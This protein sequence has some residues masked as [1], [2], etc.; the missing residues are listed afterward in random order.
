MSHFARL[1]PT[2]LLQ[3]TQKAI[4]SGELLQLHQEL[5]RLKKE[6]NTE[7]QVM[8]APTRL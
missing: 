2:E 3:E 8:A 4:G 5:I 7:T 6:L 1:K